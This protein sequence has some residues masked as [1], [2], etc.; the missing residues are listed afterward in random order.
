[1]ATYPS[2]LSDREW[3]LFALCFHRLLNEDDPADGLFDVSSTRSST[4]RAAVSHGAGCLLTTHAEVAAQEN[5]LPLLS[6][7]AH[8][9]Y[10]GSASPDAAACGAPPGIG[11]IGNETA[12]RY[13][14][15]F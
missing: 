10:L 7:V 14:D 5:G 2:N 13:R 15:G 8:G 11:T 1:M 12:F 3:S 9:W 6:P 4:S